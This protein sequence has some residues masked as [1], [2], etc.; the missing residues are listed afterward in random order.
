MDKEII[1]EYPRGLELILKLNK[2]AEFSN[3]SPNELRANVVGYE[4]LE[5]RRTAIVKDGKE[6]E[7][8]PEAIYVFFMKEEGSLDIPIIQHHIY[9]PLHLDNYGFSPEKTTKINPKRLKLNL[10]NSGRKVYDKILHLREI[11]LSELLESVGFM[12]N[13]SMEF[14]FEKA[15]KVIKND[16]VGKYHPGELKRILKE[17]EDILKSKNY[18]P[19]GE[20]VMKGICSDAGELIRKVLVNLRVEKT[21]GILEKSFIDE[22]SHNTTIVFDKKSGEWAI[23]NSKSPRK[24]Y[25]LVPKENLGEFGVS[26][27]NDE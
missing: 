4:L 1:R 23:I 8:P 20:E 3:I 22:L 19:H 6:Y 25:N 5:I 21:L 9:V 27:E 17:K 10:S 14:D 24:F 16:F 15:M 11:R 13:Q 2:P 26:L 18:S 12:I 7:I